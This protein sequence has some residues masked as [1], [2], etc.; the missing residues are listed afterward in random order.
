MF[1]QPVKKFQAFYGTQRFMVVIIY[2]VD[3]HY[4]HMIYYR[5]T[6]GNM[7]RRQRAIFGT[8]YKMFSMQQVTI[9]L[10]QVKTIKYSQH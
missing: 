5:Y 2:I 1:A 10:T 7:L 4:K 3:T 6:I 8:F 9:K